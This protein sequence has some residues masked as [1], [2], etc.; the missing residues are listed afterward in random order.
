MKK[1]IFGKE[2]PEKAKLFTLYV[3]TQKGK[4]QKW[5][6]ECSERIEVDNRLKRYFK[7]NDYVSAKIVVECTD[8]QYIEEYRKAV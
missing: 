8:G 3:S 6:G 7:D 2:R 1:T 4:R 5:A